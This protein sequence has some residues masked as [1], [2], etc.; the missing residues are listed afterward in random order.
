[1]KLLILALT[2]ALCCAS[3]H[4][5][6]Q[7]DRLESYARARSQNYRPDGRC[8][9][10][11]ANY[12][13]AV[14][15]GGIGRNG[16]NNCVPAGYYDYARHF[17]DYMQGGKC[18][19]VNVKSK[20]GNNPYRAPRGAIIVVAPGTPGTAHPRAG[21]IAIAS[22]DG[23]FWNGGNMRYGGSYNYGSKLMG[24]YVPS[25]C[26][27]GSSSGGSSSSGSSSKSCLDCLRNGGGRGCASRC[28]QGYSCQSCINYGGGYGCRSKCYSSYDVVEPNFG[29]NRPS[30]QDLMESGSM[31][32][33]QDG[34]SSDDMQD[35][36][37]GFAQ[38]DSKWHQFTKHMSIEKFTTPDSLN[39]RLRNIAR[40]AP[41]SRG[42]R[43]FLGAFNALIGAVQGATSAVQG[44]VN[45]FGKQT[46]EAL[47]GQFTDRGFSKFNEKT[48]ITVTTGLPT[49][50]FEAFMKDQLKSVVKVPSKHK[51]AIKQI[52][53]WGLYSGSNTWNAAENVF[54]VSK[55]GDVKNFQLFVNRNYECE[56]MNI[57]LVKT[58]V[59]FKLAKDI[60]V[61]SKSKATFGGAFSTTKLHW[62]SR[63][64]ALK[65]PDL[66]FVSEFFI[67]LGMN[68]IKQSRD[69]LGAAQGETKGCNK[70]PPKQSS[71]F[72]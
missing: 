51:S 64:A 31:D 27:G 24:I 21:D 1:M 36:L 18:G 40:Q 22:G 34:P 66:T 46:S 12:I 3:V 72:K 26:A 14:G 9:Y 32:F 65:Q 19:L 11:V 30:F 62:K 53:R 39:R 49:A 37:A 68:R 16:F 33:D 5:C 52:I 59:K 29:L 45:L 8:Y 54:D 20:Y 69:I 71:P 55:G 4:G 67:N 60:F 63:D 13:D 28:P 15:I 47:V 58:D 42:R 70:P 56:E 48:T 7:M 61:I 25:S 6:A 41:T 50:Y 43:L 10:H 35:T 17:A 38:L 2:A 57:V 23:R 44:I